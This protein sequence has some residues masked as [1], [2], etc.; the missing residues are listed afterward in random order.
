MTIVRVGFNV[1]G[2]AKD[3]RDFWPLV[4]HLKKATL[5]YYQQWAKDQP[6]PV[7]FDLEFGATR[8]SCRRPR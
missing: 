1:T 2:D 7:E 8:L 3:A 6:E 4:E 5:D